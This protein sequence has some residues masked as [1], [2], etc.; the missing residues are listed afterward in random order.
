MREYKETGAG[1]VITSINIGNDKLTISY[2]N[3]PKATPKKGEGLLSMFDGTVYGENGE[4][5]PA[6]EETALIVEHEDG[7]REQYL[8]QG[9]HREQ[10]EKAFDSRI[11]KKASL[12]ACIKYCN[13]NKEV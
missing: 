11:T 1:N 9:D 4:V 13:E 10:L 8:L 3:R 2:L 12:S 6:I 7:S 5:I